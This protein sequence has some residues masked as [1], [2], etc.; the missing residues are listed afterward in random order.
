MALVSTSDELLRVGQ[1]AEQ[2]NKTVRTIHFYEEMGLLS[3]VRRTKGGFRQYDDNALVR[4]HWIDRLQELGFSLA[5]IREF[6]GALQ[7]KPSGPE[8]MQ[9]LRDFYASKLVET[10]R[11]VDRLVALEGE[12]RDT[13]EY[14]QTCETCA[15]RT[16]RS[17]CSA[18][19]ESEHDGCCPPPMVAAVHESP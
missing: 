5:E 2:A 18:C 9:E 8:A 3:P 15:P 16:P 6:L 10:R 17:A 11:A 4:I 19:E 12:L 1:L 13:L 14:L 7:S